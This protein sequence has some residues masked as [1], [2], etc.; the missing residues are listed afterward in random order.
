MVVFVLKNNESA[1][2][3]RLGITVSKKMGKAVVRNRQKRHIKEAYRALEDGIVAGYDIVIL[4]KAPLTFVNF[5]QIKDDLE[6]IL[7]KHDLLVN[8]GAR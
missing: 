6:K 7:K 8:G 2:V 4:P 1:S 5:F 3:N